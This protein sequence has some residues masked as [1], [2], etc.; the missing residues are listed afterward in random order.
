MATFLRRFASSASAGK[1]MYI[2]LAA[3]T[4]PA[5]AII[6][7]N[8][9]N[10]NQSRSNVYVGHIKNLLHACFDSSTHQFDITVNQKPSGRVVFKLYDDK[11]PRT[12]RNFRELATGQ[13]GFGFADSKFHR[14]IPGVRPDLSWNYLIAH[15]EA[16]SL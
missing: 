3:S 12:A 9:P 2:F 13:H 6:N 16:C 11:V 15:P 8:S 10:E 1:N 4:I 7:E 5:Y 14:I